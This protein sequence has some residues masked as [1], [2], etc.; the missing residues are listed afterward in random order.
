MVS[1]WQTPP[2]PI[3]HAMSRNGAAFLLILSETARQNRRFCQSAAADT[4]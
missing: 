2:S 3:R 4:A 1:E